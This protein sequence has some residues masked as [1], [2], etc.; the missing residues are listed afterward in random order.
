MFAGNGG[1]GMIFKT[2]EGDLRLVM[3]KPEIRGYERLTLFPV[4]EDAFGR[5]MIK[6]D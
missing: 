1:H 6:M 4:E 3:H 5:P 2:F